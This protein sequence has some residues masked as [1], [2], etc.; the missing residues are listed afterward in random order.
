MLDLD[1]YFTTESLQKDRDE[2][3]NKEINHFLET[4]GGKTISSDISLS[5]KI[6]EYPDQDFPISEYALY[7]DDVWLLEYTT[8]RNST[9]IYFYKEDEKYNDLK[10]ALLYY[11]IPD[12]CAFGNIKSYSTTK[13][14]STIFNILI[15]YVF[16]HYHLSP[17]DPSDIDCITP[18]MLNEALDRAKNNYDSARHYFSLFRIIR[19]WLSLSSQGA[20]PERYRLNIDPTSVDNK[21][22]HKDVVNQFQGTLSTWLPFSEDELSKLMDYSLFWLEIALPE[23]IKVRD[24]IGELDLSKASNSPFYSWE[25]NEEFERLTNIKIDEINVM[26]SIRTYKKSSLENYNKPYSYVWKNQYAIALDHI[27]N[28]L[29]IFV[30]LLVGMRAREV[31]QIMLD[32]IYKDNNDEYWINITRFK[33]T[34]DPNYQGETEVMPIPYFIGDCVDSFKHLKSL[35][36]FNKKGYLF[37]SNK[38]RKILNNFTAAQI[39]LITNEIEQFTGVERIHNHRFRKTIA[40]ILINQSERNIDLIRMLFGH[41]SYAMTLKYI[42]RNPFMVNAIAEAIQVNFTE[43]FHEVVRSVRD[44]SYSGKSAERIANAMI[45]A[46]EKFAGKQLKL[47]IMNYVSH[48]LSSGEMWFIHRS[49][50]GTYCIYSGEIKK[51]DLLPCLIGKKNLGQFLTPDVDNCQLDCQFCVAIEKSRKAISDNINFY[52]RVLESTDNIGKK[53]ETMI[54]KKLAANEKHLEHLDMNHHKV[55]KTLKIKVV[56]L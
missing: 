43:D 50:L 45:T 48:L 46:P 21:K 25:P 41:E 42:A 44:E 5:S 24:Y 16:K 8:G 28:A 2:V 34:N 37:Q 52:H 56:Q 10:R 32:D 7:K 55:K 29:F 38:S 11:L 14:Y 23:L 36:D 35:S 18:A 47:Q 51:D 40:E 54:R 12:F 39:S 4:T 1:E 19:L 30:G 15:S 13:S 20:I 9:K 33:T 6:S 17:N 3:A 53:A 31:G 27:R 26:S 22:R 49:A